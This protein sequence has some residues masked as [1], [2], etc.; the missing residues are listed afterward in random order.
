MA[1]FP[2]FANGGWGAIS[3]L[4]AEAGRGRK[5]VPSLG[6]HRR[7]SLARGGRISQLS[8]PF[9]LDSVPPAE[10]RL[11]GTDSAVA[12]SV[13]QIG[14]PEVGLDRFLYVG[15]YILAPPTA[16]DAHRAVYVRPAVLDNSSVTSGTPLKVHHGPVDLRSDGFRSRFPIGCHPDPPQPLRLRRRSR[17]GD[18]KTHSVI[19]TRLGFDKPNAKT[20]GMSRVYGVPR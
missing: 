6:R 5:W 3:S 9:P 4:G 15:G 11:T 13:L 8:L 10:G 19:C 7:R 18:P 1:R 14:L 20:S 17:G 12:A 16:V 2:S